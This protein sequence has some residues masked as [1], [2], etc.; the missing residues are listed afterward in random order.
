[1]VG[2]VLS[3]A[4]DFFV[5]RR[6]EEREGTAQQ[7]RDN[8]EARVVARLVGDE[9]D[10]ISQNLTGLAELGRSFGR[11]I[12]SHDGILPTKEWDEHKAALARLIDDRETWEA[13]SNLYHNARGLRARLVLDGPNV[14]FPADRLSTLT[15]DA[16]GAAFISQQL[17][18]IGAGIAPAAHASREVSA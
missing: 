7:R 1:M 12:D 5:E 3:I 11:P 2:T 9:L 10:T 14:P 16:E 18:D 13:M 15:R 4:R 8:Q 17:R 6:R